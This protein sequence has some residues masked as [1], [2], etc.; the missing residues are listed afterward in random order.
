MVII[1]IFTFIS[2]LHFIYYVVDI[3]RE[4]KYLYSIHTFKAFK[5]IIN[6]EI[7]LCVKKEHSAFDK[8]MS[9]QTFTMKVS[10]T[11]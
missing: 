7:A 11:L 10:G 9:R 1:W 4:V 2:L 5:F 3:K 6:A 8:T